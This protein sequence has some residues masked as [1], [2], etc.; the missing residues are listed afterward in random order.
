MIEYRSKDEAEPANDSAVT[1]G[2]FTLITIL[3][4]LVACLA[5]GGLFYVTSGR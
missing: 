5:M 4:Y 3:A 1:L 2:V